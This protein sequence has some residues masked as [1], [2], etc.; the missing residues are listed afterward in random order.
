MVSARR[1]YGRP[2]HLAAEHVILEK[3]HRAGVLH[4]P[5]VE[6]G[7]KQ[8]VVLAESVRDGE[9]LVVE[10]EALLGLRENPLVVHELGQRAAAE[11]AER[12]FAVLV[13][14]DVV[15]AR[16]RPR[17]QRHQI[18]AHSR[19]RDEG[20]HIDAV[21]LHDGSRRAVG[22]HLPV[23]G[24]GHDHVERGLDV[25]LVEAR[26][27]PLRVCGFE[28]RVQV[29]LVVD[30][31]DEAMQALAR[32][33]VEAVRID[34]NTFCSSTMVSARPVDLGVAGDVDVDSV[35]GR[36]AHTA[37][38]MSM[39][40]SAPASASNVTVVKDRNVVSP[41]APSPSVRSSSIL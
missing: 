15:P 26:E 9:V 13:R 31:I 25:G 24:R 28:L 21:V 4:R 30:R 7:N 37:A 35:E 27:H 22:H 2:R 36:A 23:R 38:A 19:R 29:H 3:R 14:V 10:A 18:G 20:M 40:V 5:G 8:L 17:D 34:H 11:D 12:N 33:R 6:L 16:I 32:V 1:S 41:G 39:T